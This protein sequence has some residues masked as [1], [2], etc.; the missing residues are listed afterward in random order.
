MFPTLRTR[1]QKMILSKAIVRNI[2]I[3]AMLESDDISDD[4]KDYYSTELSTQLPD[5]I[6]SFVI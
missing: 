2:D 5:T 1:L 4:I 6:G 3:D